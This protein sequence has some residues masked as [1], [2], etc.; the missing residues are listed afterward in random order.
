MC[1][2]LSYSLLSNFL[3]DSLVELTCESD[4]RAVDFSQDISVLSLLV[5]VQNEVSSPNQRHLL[6]FE[7]FFDECEFVQ[8]E[9]HQCLPLFG[10]VISVLG[11]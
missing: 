4:T 7:S 8:E 6:F 11:S 2:Y 10:R 3:L 1:S 9:A 5:L